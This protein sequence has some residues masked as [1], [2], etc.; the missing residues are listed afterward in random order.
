MLQILVEAS[1]STEVFASSDNNRANAVLIATV[2]NTTNV[3]FLIGD[4]GNRF[5]WI[6]HKRIHQSKANTQKI[7]RVHMFLQVQQEVNQEQLN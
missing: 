4:F 5:F 7:L 2:D 6:R 1:D 3:E